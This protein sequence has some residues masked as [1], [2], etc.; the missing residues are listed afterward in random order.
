MGVAPL[1]VVADVRDH[2]SRDEGFT[3]PFAEKFAMNGRAQ[4]QGE[5]D[6]HLPCKLSVAT[7]LDPVNRVPQRMRG[8]LPMR[9]H[10]A[11]PGC[12]TTALPFFGC[13]CE[14]DLSSRPSS[15]A[16]AR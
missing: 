1:G 9:A 6:F 12:P 11:E 10:E 3:D 16:P 13:S 7:V 8:L 14:F 5:G 4:R 15:V 2:P